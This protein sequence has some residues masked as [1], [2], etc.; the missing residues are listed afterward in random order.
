M[1]DKFLR[2][3]SFEDESKGETGWKEKVV[4]AL[5]SIAIISA[6]VVGVYKYINHRMEYL[7]DD[8]LIVAE[9]GT[10]IAYDDNGAHL[11][12]GN[13]VLSDTY[14]AIEKDSYSEMCRVIN[15]DGLTGF[16][17]K[18]DGT[19]V[20]KPQYTE[21]SPMSNG[22]SCVSS[23][24]GFY[25]ISEDG[26]AITDCYEEAYPWERQGTVARVKN[27]NGWAVIDRS[28]KLLIERCDSLN[29][30]PVIGNTGT[31]V[32]DG[33]ALLLKYSDQSNEEAFVEVIKELKEF[34]EISSDVFYDE[35]AVVKGATG[36]G[37]VNCNGEVIVQPVYDNL[38]WDGYQ[39]SGEED[40]T[41]II[42]K[43]RK[44]DGRLDVIRWNPLD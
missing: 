32:R 5:I 19:E 33:H 36:Y 15:A 1:I 12:K 6:I 10:Y 22:S 4:S 13:K 11:M 7:Q 43:G 9:D 28:G 17:S 35:F 39:I 31:A 44:Q 18:K 29:N 16:V 21:A 37:A 41:E 8:S 2:T 42:F 14:L 20:I 38:E 23:G 3:L 30:L 40:V 25:F 34:F 27:K 26:D 24:N